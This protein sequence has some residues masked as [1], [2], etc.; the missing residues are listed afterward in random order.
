MNVDL[1][2]GLFGGVQLRNH[3][4]S[5]QLYNKQLTHTFRQC[6]SMFILSILANYLTVPHDIKLAFSN[7]NCSI[8]AVFSESVH[9]NSALVARDWMESMCQEFIQVGNLLPSQTKA[10][11]YWCNNFPCSRRFGNEFVPCIFPAFCASSRGGVY[12]KSYVYSTI[13]RDHRATFQYKELGFLSCFPFLV[14]C[15]FQ[16]SYQL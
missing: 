4:F 15:W 7:F 9:F 2:C 13:V 8:N 1:D 3:F 6:L 14:F 12:P 16:D 11:G 5:F 10:Q